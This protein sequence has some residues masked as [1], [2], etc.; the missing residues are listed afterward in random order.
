MVAPVIAGTGVISVDTQSGAGLGRIRIDAIDRTG[1]GFNFVNGSITSVGSLMTVFP[2]PLPRLDV[3][4]A[5]GT[6]IA[7]GSGPVIVQLPFGSTPN[8]QIKVQARDFN[9]NVPITLVLTPDHGTRIV[10]TGTINN[11]NP[12]NPATATFDVTLP[13]NE[14]VTVNA[15][16]K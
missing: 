10:Y 4:E 8:R 7:E 3:I 13:V 11:Q 12:N 5:A 16:S 2:S 15:Y 9:A 1:V 6:A 14:Q